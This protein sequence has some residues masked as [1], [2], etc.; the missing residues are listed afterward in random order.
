MAKDAAP[1]GD[2]LEEGSMHE[3]MAALEHMIQELA[4][5][6]KDAILAKQHTEIQFR[7]IH[8]RV[9][10]AEASAARAEK[11]AVESSNL[12]ESCF[13]DGSQSRNMDSEDT[14]GVPRFGGKPV[15]NERTPSKG[16]ILSGG[17]SENSAMTELQTLREAFRREEEQRRQLEAET[18]AVRAHSSQLDTSDAYHGK[19]GS[20]M[21]RAMPLPRDAAGRAAVPETGMTTSTPPRATS[22]ANSGPSHVASKAPQPLAAQFSDLSAPA[23]GS[24]AANGRHEDPWNMWQEGMQQSRDDPKR[25]QSPC[26]FSR[27]LQ[28]P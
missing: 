9:E 13:V 10:R 22:P 3:R 27:C 5:R 15:S 14:S 11:I 18:A 25:R 7:A 1:P 21:S 24:S 28:R 12:V 20:R 19:D 6:C 16:R 17:G 23:A 4:V 2:L 26:D 8:Q